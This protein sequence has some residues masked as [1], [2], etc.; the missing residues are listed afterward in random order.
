MK[1]SL[2]IWILPIVCISL[3]LISNNCK[4]ET[5][6]KKQPDFGPSVMDID[7]NI[8]HT[9]NIGTQVWMMENLKTSRYNDGS[10]IPKVTTED[11]WIKLSTP[12]FCWYNNDSIG[13]KEKYGALYNW[14]AVNTGKLCPIGWHVPNDSDWTILIAYLGGKEIAG[15][16]LKETGTEIWSTPNDG[17]SN[18]FSF[19]AIPSGLRSYDGIF[20]SKGSYAF[21]WSSTDYSIDV[22]SNYFVSSLYHDIVISGSSKTDGFSVRCIKD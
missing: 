17:A 16:K 11:Y 20:K 15:G 19:N 12:A 9:V 2:F 3:L 14:Y 7:N 6:T 10:L 1:K 22:A 5:I 13:N 18:D 8:Y 4:K 21:W